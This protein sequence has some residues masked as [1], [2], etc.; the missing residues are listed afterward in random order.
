MSDVRRK[1][2]LRFELENGELV[3]SQMESIGSDGKKA[4]QEIE[5]GAKSAD[6]R[7][8]AM[9]LTVARNLMPTLSI[10]GLI[11]VARST[12]KELADLGNAAK[13]AQVDVEKLQEFRYLAKEAGIEQ[14]AADA[15]IGDFSKRIGE[16]QQGIGKLLPV[17]EHYNIRLKDVNGRNREWE[18]VLR[19]ISAAIS[20]A[21][22]ENE[23]AFIASR[24]G[25]EQLL[26]V[27]SE[28]PSQFYQTMNSIRE[29]MNVFTTDTI[30]KAAEIDKKW[31]EVTNN[32]SVNW[33]SVLVETLIETGRFVRE[34]QNIYNK[35]N[36]PD[37][38]YTVNN[39]PKNAELDAQAEVAGFEARL[40]QQMNGVLEQARHKPKDGKTYA[41]SE[42]ARKESDKARAA[43]ITLAEQEQKKIDDVISSLEFE[44]D[45]LGRSALQQEINNQLR[46]AG[47]DLYSKEGQRIAELVTE[48][49]NYE[50]AQER[51]REAA[52]LLGD[53]IRGTGLAFQDLRTY[54]LNTLA[55]I[56]ESLANLATGGSAGNS[57][58]G[59][60]AGALYGAFSF[61]GS[62]SGYNPATA[63]PP[64]KPGFATGGSFMVG[65]DGS[66]D[67]TRVE[68]WA[69]RGERV[70][71][72]TPAQQRASNA[73][74]V[75]ITIV[76]QTG[77]QVQT[78]RTGSGGR[79]IEIVVA[80]S[81][82]KA[83]GTGRLDDALA[84]RYGLRPGVKA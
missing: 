32:F 5:K 12:T 55:D 27:L 26:G 66:T 3:K 74:P 13:R 14:T 19:D 82:S 40:R 15:I 28:G 64:R 25:V 46:Q 56:A 49:H 23:R 29:N 2:A 34:I 75:N 69:T 44:S 79:D 51:S 39:F 57:I 67:T 42:E 80:E 16:A 35:I 11:A 6:Q 7:L 48:H 68:F 8:G 30:S 37:L 38:G 18:D 54:A 50:Q 9:A 83:I 77:A 21:G 17:L 61:G 65:G 59:V 36:P 10:G 62:G 73:A 22:D 63:A 20:A 70:K 24:A 45:Q 52:K 72:E 84:G 71:V 4:L 41:E 58:G 33:K 43:S 78:R 1:Y 31:E 47:V 53:T 76:N 81:M 60:L